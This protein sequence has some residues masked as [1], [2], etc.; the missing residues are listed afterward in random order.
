M[1]GL[2]IYCGDCAPVSHLYLAFHTVETRNQVYEEIL[3]LPGKTAV[4]Y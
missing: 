2:E 3:N 1:Q 4:D